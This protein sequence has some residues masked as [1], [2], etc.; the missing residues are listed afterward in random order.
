MV[1]SLVGA[2]GIGPE[3]C[4]TEKDKRTPQNSD[5][6][7][8]GFESSKQLGCC[9]SYVDVL[10]CLEKGRAE[11]TDFRIVPNFEGSDGL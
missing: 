8:I 4:Q 9:A 10:L 5:D 6:Q 7:S 3:Y 11:L 2:V 1:F